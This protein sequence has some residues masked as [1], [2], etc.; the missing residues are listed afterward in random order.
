MLT[1][2]KLA[3]SQASQGTLQV[4]RRR[5][6]RRPS[7]LEGEGLTPAERGSALHQFMQ[8]CDYEKARQDPVQEIGRL[9][10]LRLLSAAQ[11][12]AVDPAQVAR[13]FEGPLA[14]RIFAAR[15]V[16][17][18]YSFLGEL[19]AAQLAPYLSLP[20]PGSRVLL[21]GIADCIFL[22]GEGAVLVDYKTDRVTD[23]RQLAGHY[24]GQLQLYRLLLA[25]RLPVPVA[26]GYLYSFWL[27]QEI[28]I[29]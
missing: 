2:A 22:E 10:G 25:G 24:G 13:F 26:E 29:F 27:G 7:F 3:V 12:D 14:R 19:D 16:L 11:A 18:E 8:L 23:P 28:R 15:R 6:A 17:R 21:Q 5:F 4:A 20:A 1:P 9:R